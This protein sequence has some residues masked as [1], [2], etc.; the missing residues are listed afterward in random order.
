MKNNIEVRNVNRSFS[1]ER[2]ISYHLKLPESVVILLREE[3]KENGRS[4]S[5]EILQILKERVR[6]KINEQ[7][8]G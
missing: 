6:G 7:R 3:A 1:K 2:Q 5:S 8:T 4:L